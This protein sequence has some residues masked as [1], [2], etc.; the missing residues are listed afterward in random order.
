MKHRHVSFSDFMHGLS[1]DKVF[2][3]RQKILRWGFRAKGA[4]FFCLKCIGIET[5][6]WIKWLFWGINS[7]EVCGPKRAR[8]GPKNDFFLVIWRIETDVSIFFFCVKL[9]QQRIKIA[10]IFFL[11]KSCFVVFRAEIVV[12]ARELK[13]CFSLLCMVF[14]KII[15]P[16][17]E[18]NCR[19]KFLV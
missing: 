19:T 7:F 13:L 18:N 10:K 8:N 12:I 17:L 11:E 9:Q 1:Q 2:K 14:I 16:I 4:R 6:N 3:L 5:Q 15:S